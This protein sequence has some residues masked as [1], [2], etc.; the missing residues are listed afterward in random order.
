MHRSP[1]VKTEIRLAG[2]QDKVKLLPAVVHTEKFYMVMAKTVPAEAVEKMRKAI[3]Q[4]D[5]SG[6]LAKLF[7]KRNSD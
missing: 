5:R 1:G 3:S 7:E 2:M 4:L 6:E